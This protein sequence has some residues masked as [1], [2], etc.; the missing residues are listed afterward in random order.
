MAKT[1]RD[2]LLEVLAAIRSRT[3][4][5][6]LG[7]LVCNLALLTGRSNTGGVYDIEDDELLMAAR[8]HLADLDHLPPEM[9][10]SIR[11]TVG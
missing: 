1:M 10:N 9:L 11:S 5:V 7:Q 4:S 2:D 3:P 8:Q 6:R